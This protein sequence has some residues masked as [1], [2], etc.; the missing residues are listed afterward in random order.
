VFGTGPT[1]TLASASTAV[2]QSPGDNTT[3]VATDAFVIANAGSLTVQANGTGAGSGATLNFIPGTYITQSVPACSG[4]VCSYQPDVDTTRITT[5]SAIQTFQ[6]N[7]LTTTSSSPT[8]YTANA[9]ASPGT[10]VYAA[11]QLLVWN[12]GATA[13]T[14]GTATTLAVNG[15][16]PIPVKQSDGVT[17]PTST[18]C[19]ANT[20]VLIVYDATLAVYR[21]H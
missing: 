19:A 3:K 9:A 2:T 8:A 5:Y 18:Q 13:C 16:S 21:I 17:N 10:F 1:I 4:G 6:S 20:P 15:L 11:N 7:V 14:G 12:V